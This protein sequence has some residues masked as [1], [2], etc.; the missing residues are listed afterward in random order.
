M[1][2]EDEYRIQNLKGFREFLPEESKARNEVF[3]KISEVVE[4]YGFREIGTPSLEPMDLYLI[5]SGEELV[6]QT[7]SF[8]DKGG[9]QV[10]LPPEET[11]TRARMVKENKDLTKPIKW[12]SF[13]KFW[14][15]E[16]P[17]KG[18]LREFYQVNI[19]IF[20]EDSINADAEILAV[21][22][23]ILDA[24]DLEEAAELRINDRNLMEGIIQA[25]GIEDSL[26]EEILDVIDDKEK[27][28]REEFLVQLQELGLSRENAKVVDELTEI[29]G[30]FEGVLPKVE[31][32]IPD[33]EES[34]KAFERIKKLKGKLEQ[35]GVLDRCKLDLSIIRGLD[36]YTGLV[37]E[38]FDKKGDLRALCGG[39]RYNDLIQ[40][41]NGPETP[42]VGFA[43]GDAVLEEL[44]KREGVWPEE[45]FET[46]VYVLN[47][48]ED[49]RPKAVELANELRAKGYVVETDLSGRN[50]GNQMDYA[51]QINAENL[52]IVGEKDLGQD[53]VT[54]KD[55]DSGEEEKV[56]LDDFADYF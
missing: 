38:I 34:E 23:D 6:E 40:L 50:F 36:Y 25:Y 4:S 16:N 5:K 2:G 21:A 17:Q 56:N 8:E 26:V 13:S 11:P 51:N 19:D 49:V 32:L 41:F 53:Q 35:Y 47:V 24:L 52:V 27:M 44:M 10:T 12:Y 30:R 55:M 29:R 1:S 20:G 37:F 33:K 31:N 7:Y 9:R 18:R 42:A 14:R 54:V 43:I 39:G 15:Y 46:D 28:D 3:E 22:A 45:E 48:S